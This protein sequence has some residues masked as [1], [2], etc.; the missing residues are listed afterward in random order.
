MPAKFSAWIVSGKGKVLFTNP[1][2]VVKPIPPRLTPV[3]MI[4]LPWISL[5]KAL[6]TSRFSV[7]ALKSGCVVEAIVYGVIENWKVG[8]DG[9]GFFEIRLKTKLLN[10]VQVKFES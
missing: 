6:A 3:T 8:G 7:R 1:C 5:A 4:V 2:A 9:K 10:A